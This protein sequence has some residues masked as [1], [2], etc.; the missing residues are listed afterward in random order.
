MTSSGHINA[1]GEQYISGNA[2][3]A[4]TSG[5]LRRHDNAGP[6]TAAAALAVLAVVDM[7]AF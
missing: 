3:A 6:W 7:L 5:A 2:S 4:T 1:L